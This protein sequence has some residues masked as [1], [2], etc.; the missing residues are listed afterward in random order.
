[1][2]SGFILTWTWYSIVLLIFRSLRYSVCY[3]FCNGWML[4]INTW[5][6][7]ISLFFSYQISSFTVTHF[8]SFASI[9]NMFYLRI[10]ISR[11]WTIIP[12]IIL[13][14][15]S[16]SDTLSIVTKSLR[17]IIFSWSWLIQ[18][19]LGH[20]ISSH[21]FWNL[22]WYYSIFHLVKFCWILS[23]SWNITLVFIIWSTSDWKL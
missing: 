2:I 14:S 21:T 22:M 10:I 9:F 15:T 6:R 19:L 23:W 12:R 7:E 5:S 3:S 1:M 20:Y 18:H 17:W 11:S 13:W 4:I 16:N 8:I